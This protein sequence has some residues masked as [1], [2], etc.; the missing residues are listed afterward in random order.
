[1]I[2]AVGV[3]ELGALLGVGLWVGWHNLAGGDRR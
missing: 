1:M 3:F 2:G